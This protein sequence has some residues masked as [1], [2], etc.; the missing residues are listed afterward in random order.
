MWSS[1][2]KETSNF[3]SLFEENYYKT[4]PN[5]WSIPPLSLFLFLW[6]E[7]EIITWRREKPLRVGAMGS[8]NPIYLH[9]LAFR[10]LREHCKSWQLFRSPES[11]RGRS[12][13][14]RTNLR[15][16]FCGCIHWEAIDG[17]RRLGSGIW[18]RRKALS[19][20]LHWKQKWKGNKKEIKETC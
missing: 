2:K 15:G 20:L 14:R 6:T 17:R 11:D 7:G 5:A 16:G 18:K 12:L 13:S 19:Q 3:N 8:R 9:S 1:L 4:F 10:Y